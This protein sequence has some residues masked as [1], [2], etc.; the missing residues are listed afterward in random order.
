MNPDLGK[1]EAMKFNNE[2]D[3]LTNS[4]PLRQTEINRAVSSGVQASYLLERLRG[5]GGGPGGG[6][7]GE[8]R[9]KSL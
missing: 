5:V 8:L 7:G 9:D 1:W 2:R 6:E 3:G 4:T